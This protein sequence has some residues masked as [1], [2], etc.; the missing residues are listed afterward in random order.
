MSFNIFFSGSSP[1][2]G[3]SEG[4]NKVPL[5]ESFPSTK[6]IDH[7]KSAAIGSVRSLAGDPTSTNSGGAT[8][9]FAQG[10]AA[11]QLTRVLKESIGIRMIAGEGSMRVFIKKKGW[12][13]DDL[14]AGNFIFSRSM[15]DDEMIELV[16]FL[17]KHNLNATGPY[18]ALLKMFS[19][20]STKCANGKFMCMV[21]FEM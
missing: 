16:R 20:F 11:L 19:K 13:V 4:R 2:K 1:G 12:F 15:A 21:E 7:L 18:A 14:N 17:G 9:A 8:V 5:G 3:F 10:V 6:A